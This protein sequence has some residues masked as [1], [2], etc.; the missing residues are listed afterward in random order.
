MHGP[1]ILVDSMVLRSGF[2]HGNEWQYHSRSDH[3]SKIAC[4][5]ILLDL[6]L[7][8]PLLRQH[9]ADLKVGFGI[10]HEMRDF[11]TGRK[12]DLDLVIC[13]PGDGG[14]DGASDFA[15]LAAKIGIVL[16][17]DSRAALDSLP[18][19]PQFTVGAVHVALEAKACMTE[20]IKARPR[21]YDE[22]NSSHL[23]IHGSSE[24]TI[25]VGVAM[26]NIASEFI[27]PGRNDF[28]LST[29]DPVVSSHNQ[30][31]VTRKVIEKLHEMPRRTKIGDTGFDAFG[32][33]VVDCR[34]DGSRV[35]LVEVPPAPQPS[36]IYHYGRMINRVAHL[37]EQKFKEI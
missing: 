11:K 7:E 1:K 33:T 23:A 16:D 12:K 27:S 29:R 17:Q 24:H 28:D 13:R 4:W 31:K 30:P 10:N 21:L 35:K 8:C 9:A 20:H 5:G 14:L 37:Y 3:H 18:A 34:N 2:K 19:M 22:L 36:E 26:V 25:A 32:I 15:G 6:L